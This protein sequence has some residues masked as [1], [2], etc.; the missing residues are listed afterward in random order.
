M[1]DKIYHFL[2]TKQEN[3]S[4]LV[5]F[6]ISIALL[7]IVHFISI[8]PDFETLYLPTDDAIINYKISD[9]FVP[10]YIVTLPKIIIFLNK[11][12]LHVS[13]SAI[14]FQILFILCAIS[15]LLGFKQ[16]LSALLLLFL[17]ISLTKSNIY[18][19]YGIDYFSS[20][21]LFYL[22]IIPDDLSSLALPTFK[23]VFQTH[24]SI[25]YFF[26]GFD[27]I[28]GTNWWNGENIWKSLHLPF[29]T[30]NYDL[31]FLF[32]YPSFLSFFGLLIVFLELLYPLYGWYSK[33]SR[34]FVYL[35]IIMHITIAFILNLYFFSAIMIIWNLT[36]LMSFNNEKNYSFL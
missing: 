33:N 17:Q 10:D 15:L 19:T 14:L 8:L 30:S 1:M 29:A 3:T 7:I 28:I 18:Y 5:F 12:G 31:T 2:F 21:S 20:I 13:T 4:W 35:I 11:I 34:L 6:R 22:S 16:N 26:A 32:K 25:A 24:I 27:K 23:R 9:V 36:F